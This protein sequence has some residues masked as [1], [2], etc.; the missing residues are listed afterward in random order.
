MI[1]LNITA[2][3]IEVAASLNA[4]F[5]PVWFWAGRSKKQ[6]ITKCFGKETFECE[7]VKHWNHKIKKDEKGNYWI[8]WGRGFLVYVPE[9]NCF[10]QR[11]I[12]KA[13]KPLCDQFKSRMM[14]LFIQ[15]VQNFWAFKA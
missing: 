6:E 5:C 12:S 11:N 8:S 4:I 1:E 13:N 15:F 14:K 10:V 7:V 3:E 9:H 2:K